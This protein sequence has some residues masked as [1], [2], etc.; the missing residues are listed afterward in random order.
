MKGKREMKGRL[1]SQREKGKLGKVDPGSDIRQ[2]KF[3]YS[4]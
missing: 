1:S 3:N 2:Q 4:F